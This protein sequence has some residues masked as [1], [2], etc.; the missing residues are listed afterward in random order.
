MRQT[1][2]KSDQGALSEKLSDSEFIL[3]V[4]PTGLA[5]ALNT[6]C[7]RKRNQGWPQGMR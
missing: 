4:E 3:K 6:G 7:G 1:I 5:D 2:G